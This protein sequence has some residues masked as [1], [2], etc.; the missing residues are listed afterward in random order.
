MAGGFAD[1][2][3]GGSAGDIAGGDRRF[4]G[5]GEDVGLEEGGGGAIDLE[6][7]FGE[8]AVA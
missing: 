3:G 4:D 6:G 2:C 7:E 1:P 5:D 8:L